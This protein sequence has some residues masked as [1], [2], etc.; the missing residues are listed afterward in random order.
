MVTAWETDGL[1]AA[2]T[3]PEVQPVTEQDGPQYGRP[4]DAGEHRRATDSGGYGRPP[5]V[6]GPFAPQPQPR[7]VYPAAAHRVPSR[8][9]HL[10]PPGR[11]RAIRAGAR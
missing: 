7:T 11:R 6:D 8:T 10:L 1:G 5:G 2:W 3:H 9:G 4:A